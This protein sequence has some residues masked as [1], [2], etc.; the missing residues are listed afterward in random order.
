[1]T[2]LL[3]NR[4]AAE[5]L[6]NGMAIEEKCLNG[7]FKACQHPRIDF[8]KPDA[9]TYYRLVPT[10]ITRTVT[11]PKSVTD[12]LVVGDKYYTPFITGERYLSGFTWQND[13]IDNRIF[14]RGLIYLTEADAIARSKA[15]IGGVE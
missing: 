10:T 11:Y 3:T 12:P 2:E 5:A 8:S 14:S 1:M 9:P 4:E 6:F 15:M 13:D 7:S